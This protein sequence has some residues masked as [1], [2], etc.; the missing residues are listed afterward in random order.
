MDSEIINAGSGVKI[1][2]HVDKNEQ[3]HIH[4]ITETEIQDAVRKGNAYNINTGWITLTTASESGVMYFENNEA[5][6]NGESG[7]VVDAIEV[8]VDSAGTTTAGL[9]AD[10]TVVR[11][12]TGGT[13]ISTAL[14]VDMNA[15]RNFGSSNTLD[16]TTLAYKGAEGNTV[17]GGSDIALFG[18]NHGLRGYF[19]VDLEVP[20]GNSVAIK[21]N[22]QTTSGN[23]K[24]YCAIVGHRIDGNNK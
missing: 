8:Y 14:A 10:I 22:T 2:A 5:P 7:F 20:K 9:P 4:A 12:P 18:Q 24:V 6:V 15:N 11:N 1:G 17:T 13:L 21:I 3:L 19:N 16:S 23:T